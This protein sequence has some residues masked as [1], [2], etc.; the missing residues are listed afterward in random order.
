MGAKPE[1]TLGGAVTLPLSVIHGLCKDEWLH[2]LRYVP[3]C[4]ACTLAFCIDTLIIKEVPPF[5]KGF[6]PKVMY[7]LEKHTFIHVWYARCTSIIVDDLPG[8]NPDNCV[9]I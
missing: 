9:I 3:L 4:T 1:M 5:V 7:V 6:C 2:G 8:I